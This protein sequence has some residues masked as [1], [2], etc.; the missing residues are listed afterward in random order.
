MQ[1]GGGV[2][3]PAYDTLVLSL[4]PTRYYPGDELLGPDNTPYDS[5]LL[6]FGPRIFVDDSFTVGA[7]LDS[8]DELMLDLGPD[9]YVPGDE[10]NP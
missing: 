8:Y 4:G 1:Q 10:I 9:R 7:D 3:Y 6:A 2:V 5:L